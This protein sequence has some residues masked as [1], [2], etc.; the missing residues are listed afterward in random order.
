MR[1]QPDNDLHRVCPLIKPFR[2]GLV[3]SVKDTTKGKGNG[4]ARS[5][6]RRMLRAAKIRLTYDA[7]TAPRVHVH[8]MQTCGIPTRVISANDPGSHILD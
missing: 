8:A 3:H 6:L 1:H 7:N 4:E 2:L 5:G